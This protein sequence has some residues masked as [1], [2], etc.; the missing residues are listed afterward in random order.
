[1]PSG[2]RHSLLARHTDPR[3]L[4]IAFG[5]LALPSLEGSGRT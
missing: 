5:C 4:V 2:H 1:M 3:S